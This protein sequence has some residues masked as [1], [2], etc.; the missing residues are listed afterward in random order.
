MG[1]PE[2]RATMDDMHLQRRV[3]LLSSW[4]CWSQW[5]GPSGYRPVGIKAAS[6]SRLRLGRSEVLR[7]L[8]KT[9]FGH[10]EN[11]QGHHNTIDRLE[12]GGIENGSGGRCSLERR[13]S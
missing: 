9:I 1:S 13:D 2:W 7:S 12:D 3:C 8:S 6:T 4:T 10:T 5:K 11:S